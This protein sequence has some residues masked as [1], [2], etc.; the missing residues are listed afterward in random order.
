MF[1]GLPHVKFRDFLDFR[2]KNFM[3]SNYGSENPKPGV[4]PEILRVPG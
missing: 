2:S 1:L 3:N 4:N